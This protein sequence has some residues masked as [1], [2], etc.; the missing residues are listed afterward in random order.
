MRIELV[1]D[2]SKSIPEIAD[3]NKYIRRQLEAKLD[4]KVPLDI[5][6]WNS[7]E[8]GGVQAADLFSWGIFRK[9]EKRDTEW[10]K[11]FTSKI[12]YESKYLP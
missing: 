5:Y 6:H 3:F 7:E 11:I 10:Y 1:I 4:P 8:N 2:K 9:Y 12:R